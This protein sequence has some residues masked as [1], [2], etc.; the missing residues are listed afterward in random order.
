MSYGPRPAGRHVPTAS[1][2]PWPAPARCAADSGDETAARR[3][4]NARA[5]PAVRRRHATNAGKPFPRQSPPPAALRPRF[6]APARAIPLPPAPAFRPA[7]V[8]AFPAP[9]PAPPV[10][11][12]RRPATRPTADTPQSRR[13]AG[14]PPGS[15]PEPPRG[16]RRRSATGRCRR[17]PGN[18]IAIAARP[19]C[20]LAPAL[21]RLL[22]RHFPQPLFVVDCRD[23]VQ[24]L[25]P[26]QHPPLAAVEP[27]NDAHAER[28]L[29][30]PRPPGVAQHVN[31]QR[32]RQ[33]RRRRVVIAPVEAARLQRPADAARPAPHMR[34]A[35]VV[36]P[37]P[38]IGFQFTPSVPIRRKNP[39]RPT[40]R[41][42][43]AFSA[44]LICQTC[45]FSPDMR[46]ARRSAN[47][48]ANRSSAA[49]PSAPARATTS[50]SRAF[51]GDSG[52]PR[53]KG[54]PQ[55]AQV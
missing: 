46:A 35:G 38:V 54:R 3:S 28:Q 21:A 42:P 45:D 23:M 43:V 41:A 8:A 37:A 7:P 40:T 55:R 25:A 48:M 22:S 50:N 39:P 32:Q 19:S 53:R 10:R 49:I 44:W 1:A 30:P 31:Q 36:A 52:T 4:A 20:P 13:P 24:N 12:L 27:L 15:G 26:R 9:P 14:S 5:A 47:T 6:P 17:A 18:G 11:P 33:R 51:N 2:R 34:R 16:R 29:Q